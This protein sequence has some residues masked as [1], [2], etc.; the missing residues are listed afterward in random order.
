MRWCET[1][2]EISHVPAA[3]N[4]GSVS[5]AAS[6]PARSLRNDGRVIAGY[7]AF[8]VDGTAGTRAGSR[9]EGWRARGPGRASMSNSDAVVAITG[10][11]FSF[12]TATR[13]RAQGEVAGGSGADPQ[14]GWPRLG[15]SGPLLAVRSR[16]RLS[17]PTHGLTRHPSPKTTAR[18]CGHTSTASRSRQARVAPHPASRCETG[19]GSRGLW[20]AVPHNRRRCQDLP[21]RCQVRR[22]EAAL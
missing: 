13:A 1:A 19:C 8:A 4:F 9:R 5:D 6:L 7:P 11:S 2:G 20:R 12:G 18:G 14:T 16:G 3:I 15:R 22:P 17:V 21:R 10:D